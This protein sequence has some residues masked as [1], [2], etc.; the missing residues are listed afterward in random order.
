MRQ[1]RRAKSLAHLEEQLTKTNPH[2]LRE[3]K[4]ISTPEG[5]MGR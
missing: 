1:R 5:T 2:I 4:T 3:I